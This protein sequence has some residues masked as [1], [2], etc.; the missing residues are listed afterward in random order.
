MADDDPFSLLQPLNHLPLSTWKDSG[1]TLMPLDPLEKLTVGE[2]SPASVLSV[3]C[4][5]DTRVLL[6]VTQRFLSFIQI[7]DFVQ[8][9]KNHISSYELFFE[10]P[11]C[12]L[13]LLV[14]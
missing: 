2:H 7:L 8:S 5:T 1:S 9:C 3:L 11:Y 14:V 10:L 13:L 4:V 12:W 6:S